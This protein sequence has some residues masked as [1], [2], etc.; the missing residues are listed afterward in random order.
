MLQLLIINFAYLTN[1][2]NLH[3]QIPLNTLQ[4]NASSMAMIQSIDG[5]LHS[6]TGI[7]W[8]N[9]IFTIRQ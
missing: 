6:D 1:W 2:V 4:I 5:K 9:S 7:Q 8:H 3:T